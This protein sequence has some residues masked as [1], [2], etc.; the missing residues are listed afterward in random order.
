MILYC[1]HCGERHIDSGEFATKPH[2]THA[3][4]T[5]G[6]TWRPA[7]VPTVGVQFLPGFKDFELVE[8]EAA[9]KA[10]LEFLFGPGSSI[11]EQEP[12][13]SMARSRRWVSLCDA[14]KAA[15]KKAGKAVRE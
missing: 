7:K 10:V 11:A 12:L 6:E 2:H 14:V 13:D 15:R 8:L 4:Q 1:M 9:E 5:C 3:C